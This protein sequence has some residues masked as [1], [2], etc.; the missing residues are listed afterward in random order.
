MPDFSE[1]LALRRLNDLGRAVQ[2]VYNPGAIVT[3]CSDAI[4]FSGSCPLVRLEDGL[5]MVPADVIGVSDADAWDFNEA[6]KKIISGNALGHL[7]LLTLPV[8]LPLLAPPVEA[9][10]S[11]K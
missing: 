2:E 6:M 8:S 7:R 1:E 5:I 9:E 3:V 10:V 4:V 11:R